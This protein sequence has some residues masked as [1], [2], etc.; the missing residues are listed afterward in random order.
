MLKVVLFCANPLK[1]QSLKEHYK[2]IK[3]PYENWTLAT[4]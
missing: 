2:Y 3:N 1:M 4:L